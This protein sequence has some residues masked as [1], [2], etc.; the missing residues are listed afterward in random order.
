MK[1]IEGREFDWYAI[2]EN[3]DVAV[4]STAG[5]GTVPHSVKENYEAHDLISEELESNNWGTQRVWDNLANYGLFVFDWKLN[6][7]PYI[8]K[9]TPKRNISSEL[10]SKILNVSGIPTLAMVFSKIEETKL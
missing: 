8:K 1:E 7:G 3:G 10:K 4:F 2:D 9:S 5:S 6:N